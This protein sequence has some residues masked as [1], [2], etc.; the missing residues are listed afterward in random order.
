MT[1]RWFV[2]YAVLFSL[3]LVLA[4]Q[5]QPCSIARAAALFSN[6]AL[7]VVDSAAGT[8]S[9]AIG[10][11]QALLALQEALMLLEHDPGAVGSKTETLK[12][13]N[14]I[15]KQYGN[16]PTEEG[17]RK[18]VVLMALQVVSRNPND[19]RA[20]GVSRKLLDMALGSDSS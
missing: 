10:E 7:S 11:P 13:V 17:L 14:E 1:V 20:K 5:K 3:G 6:A 19:E 12:V 18:T 8:G 9:L 15:R 2:R 16:E 4:N